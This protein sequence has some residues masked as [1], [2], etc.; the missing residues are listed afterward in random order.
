MVSR[1]PLPGARRPLPRRL[2]RAELLKSAALAGGGGAVLAGGGALLAACGA[3]QPG[4][5]GADAAP[6]APGGAALPSPRATRAKKEHGADLVAVAQGPSA[7]DNVER[8]VAALGGMR[9]FVKRGDVVVV[10]PNMVHPLPP[11]YAVTTDPDVV[12]TLVRLA[13]RAGADEVLVMDNPAGG[14]AQTIYDVSGIAAAVKAAGG[15]MHVMGQ[16]LY[17]RYRI[18][19]HLLGEHPLYQPVVDADVL[20]NVPVAKQHGSTGLTLAGKNMMGV[21][22][23]RGRMHRL[24]LSE[25]IAELNAALRPDLTVIDATRIL[26]AH[27]PSGGDLADVRRRDTVI[28]SADWVAADAWTTRLFGKTPESVPYI[29]AGARLGLGT[30]RLADVTI[31]KV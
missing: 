29:A 27:G 7:A 18:P 9:S 4:G 20:I 16:P 19:G 23:D 15:T 31:R 13:L 8:A 6:P 14:D 5:V 25:S 22:D 24:G 11:Q 17:R 1:P 12:A 10:K 2:T 30:D 28:A 3:G 21:T 26:V